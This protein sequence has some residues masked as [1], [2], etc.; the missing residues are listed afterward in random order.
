MTKA[1]A[2]A[3]ETTEQPKGFADMIGGD[4]ALA[5]PEEDTP[6]RGLAYSDTMELDAS[7]I[8]YPRLRLAQALTKEVADGFAQSGDWV[9]TGFEPEKQVTLIPLLGTKT[10]EYRDPD[11][12]SQ[13]LCSSPDGKVGHGDPG[14]DCSV[15]PLTAWRK[16]KKAGDKN[17]PPLCGLGY[18]YVCWSVTHD[19]LVQ[20]DFKKSAT[21]A[22]KGLNTM[23][24]ARGFG[25]FG[26]LLTTKTERG[27]RGQWHVPAMTVTKASE[28]DLQRAAEAKATVT[29]QAPA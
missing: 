20:V 7:D 26:I 14:G 5:V 22:A 9:L 3:D 21:T 29:G 23:I 15:C 4:Q 19:T 25:K 11:D 10:R 2:K 13:L 24:Q 6:V 1:N 28:E 27:A 17:L 16:P 12:N 8:A 18:S